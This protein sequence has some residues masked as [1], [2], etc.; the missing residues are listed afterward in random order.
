[1]YEYVTIFC[2]V[3]GMKGGL[4]N[5]LTAAQYDFDVSKQDNKTR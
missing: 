1:M 5:K 4:K 2:Q 3:N